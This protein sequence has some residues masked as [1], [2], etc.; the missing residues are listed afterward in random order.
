[1]VLF[2]AGFPEKVL[3]YSVYDS[4]G[5][6]ILG[7]ALLA[8]DE[9]SVHYLRIRGYFYPFLAMLLASISPALL[10]L[11]QTVAISF[12]VIFLCKIERKI[13]GKICYAPAALL[14]IS[15]LLSPAHLMSESFSFFFA[16]VALYLMVSNKPNGWSSFFLFLAALAKPAF[17]PVAILSLILQFRFNWKSLLV[18]ASIAII[19]APQ[20]ILTS[21]TAEGITFSDAGKLNFTNR[22][23]PAVYG[24]AEHG[25]FVSYRSA[26]AQEAKQ[27]HPTT[28]DQIVFVFS[29]FGSAVKAYSEIL[30]S[31]HF[32]TGSGYL[33][34]SNEVA[35]PRFK[36]AFAAL[37]HYLNYILTLLMLP[38]IIG[39]FYFFRH[40]SISEML[41]PLVGL[42]LIATA[43]LV[44]WQ[45]DRVIFIGVILLLPFVGEGVKRVKSFRD[46]L[47]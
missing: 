41:A 31:S 24:Y 15:L 3:Y 16:S 34:K 45:G 10:V 1:M 37:S 32:L 12:G 19:C 13:Y 36:N 22:F 5:Y 29:N 2:R 11:S 21:R 42:S 28:K 14:S 47:K 38:A 7:E 26:E 43:P 4:N 20:F 6:R 44:Y 30:S 40:R 39:S 18:I 46:I 23:F 17:L 33:A 25:E 8:G 27:R 35:S 9:V